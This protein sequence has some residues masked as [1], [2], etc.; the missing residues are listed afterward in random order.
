MITQLGRK[1]KI[2]L[3]LIIG[4]IM[5]SNIYSNKT[6]F[7]F[8]NMVV[9]SSGKIYEDDRFYKNNLE[10]IGVIYDGDFYLYGNIKLDFIYDAFYKE[11]AGEGFLINILSNKTID[12]NEADID[13]LVLILE[14]LLNIKLD[15]KDKSS[16]LSASKKN[17][18]KFKIVI[19]K[20]DLWFD[21]YPKTSSTNAYFESFIAI[22][23]K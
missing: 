14:K 11:M 20:Y 15:D 5:S 7:A 2:L 18:P 1:K 12:L 3:L 16:L 6:P 4:V 22:S 23:K 10:K 9:I 21:F 8:K 17:T 13:D 19:D